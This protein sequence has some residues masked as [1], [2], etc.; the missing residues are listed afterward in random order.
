MF[1]V[2]IQNCT[3]HS[4]NGFAELPLVCLTT[5]MKKTVS[6]QRLGIHIRKFQCGWHA[7]W[8]QFM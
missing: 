1:Y 6:L 5:L 7:Q 4:D 3:P 2:K 8:P